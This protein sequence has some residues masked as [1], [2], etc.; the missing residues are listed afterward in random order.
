MIQEILNKGLK[1][2]IDNPK[3]FSKA[4]YEAF[5]EKVCS[6]CPGVIQEKFNKLLNTNEQIIQ[7]MKSR[8]WR[9]LPGKLI[10]TLMSQ[11][12]PQG[13]Y[14]DANITDEVAEALIAKGYGKYFKKVEG[15]EEIEI[16]VT[17]QP[18]IEEE[19]E[20]SPI[21]F[22]VFEKEMQEEEDGKTDSLDTLAYKK[23]V[24]K[25]ESNPE[26]Y[27]KGEWQD[28]NRQQ[29]IAYIRSK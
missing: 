15:F 23:L 27:P 18:E 4:Y 25:C 8:K 3:E 10:D 14:T 21:E 13:Q 22:E 11:T 26:L 1:Y 24:K 20:E 7:N 12:G 19:I 2:S 28:K 16:P 17:T 9:M 6:Y 29:L 5:G